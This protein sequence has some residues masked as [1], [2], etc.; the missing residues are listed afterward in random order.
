MTTHL[1]RFGIIA[2]LFSGFLVFIWL[3][4]ALLFPSTDYDFY[5]FCSYGPSMHDLTMVGDIPYF[6]TRTVGEELW[7]SDGTVD[8]TVRVKVI[9]SGGNSVESSNLTNVQG[10]LFFIAGT[11]PKRDLW[12]SD[13]TEVG[14]V[15]VMTLPNAPTNLTNVH[16]TLFFTTGFGY[17]WKSD[18]SASGTGSL[19]KICSCGPTG[20]LTDFID[21]NGTLFFFTPG[22]EELWKSDG[23]E[24]GTV[25]VEYFSAGTNYKPANVTSVNGTLFFTL[26]DEKWKSDGTAVGTVRV[27]VSNPESNNANSG[28]QTNRHQASYFLSADGHELWKIG[29]TAP[30]AVR[31]ATINPGTPNL[32]HQGGLR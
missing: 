23:S 26:A 30:G 17:L 16:G 28:T 32:N 1:R 31:V 6:V 5:E 18:G 21:V 8:G 19:K 24:V 9:S 4:F 29:G 22:H 7:K 14:T 20:Y 11:C 15:R 10:T 25:R 12:K 27:T 3:I 13:G 2:M